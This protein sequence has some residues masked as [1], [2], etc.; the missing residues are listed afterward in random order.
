MKDYGFGGGSGFGSGFDWNGN[1]K[2]DRFDDYMNYK[3]NGS[4]KDGGGSKGASGNG[5]QNSAVCLLALLG[6][7]GGVRCVFR[8]DFKNWE[9]LW[10]FFEKIRCGR[11]YISDYFQK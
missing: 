7:V 11:G 5:G 9:L 10:M 8:E 6:F 4:D 2:A 1:G 3:A